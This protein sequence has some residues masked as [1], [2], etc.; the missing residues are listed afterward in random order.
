MGIEMSTVQFS[1]GMKY[2]QADI[3]TFFV[4]FKIYAIVYKSLNHPKY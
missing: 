3:I 1:N 4:H 2:K